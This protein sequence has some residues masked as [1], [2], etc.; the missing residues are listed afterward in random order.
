MKNKFVL[1][2]ALSLVCARGAAIATEPFDPDSYARADRESKFVVVQGFDGAEREKV[3]RECVAIVRGLAE[4]YGKP[5]YW[6]VFPVRF[7]PGKGGAIAGYTS[8][9][10][11]SVTEVAIF[12]TFEESRGGT[13]D[14]ELT[15]AFF[16]HYLESNFDL[17]LNE[18]LA[19]NSETANRA[20]LRN[21]VCARFQAGD[22]APLA[23]LYGSNRYDSG[24][25]MYVEGFGVVD[26]LLARGGSKWFAAFM[27]DLVEKD[28][29][30][31][32]LRRFYG[33]ASLDALEREWLEYV[34]EGQNRATVRAVGR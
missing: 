16:F 6:R 9:R 11:P 30:E 14:H 23:S 20:R 5:R 8:Y 29:V 3:E 34:A 25:L 12:Q 31:A 28:D 32:S 22:F 10:R 24:L 2:L 18:G 19:Q 4:R 26:Y 7:A 1:A 13:L 33:I 17:L 15:H 21:W 27:I